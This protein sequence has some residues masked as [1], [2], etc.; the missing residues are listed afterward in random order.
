MIRR[1]PGSTRTD[2]RFPYTTR[3]RSGQEG[4]QEY[5]LEARVGEESPLAGK[6]LRETSTRLDEHDATLLGLKR[7][8]VTIPSAAQWTPV[9]AGDTLLIEAATDD[10]GRSDERRVGKECVSTCRY[11]W[12]PAH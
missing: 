6:P 4:V 12:W 7:G 1:P 8:E 9:R 10:V 11:R 2:T 5:L 3:F